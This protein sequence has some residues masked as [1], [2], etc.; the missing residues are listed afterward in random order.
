LLRDAHVGWV[1]HRMKVTVAGSSPRVRRRAASARLRPKRC[2]SSILNDCGRIAVGPSRHVPRAGEATLPARPRRSARVRRRGASRTK[3]IG[4][5]A[6]LVGD[7]DHATLL[8]A[9]RQIIA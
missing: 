6:V 3:L 5:I 2:G 4:N 1:T 9:G 8:R 7:K